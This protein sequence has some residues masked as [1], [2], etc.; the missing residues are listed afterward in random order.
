MDHDDD[1]RLSSDGDRWT[2]TFTRRLRHPQAKVWRAV[3]EPDGLRAWFPQRIEGERRAGAPLRF[4]HEDGSA[5]D[6]EMVAFEPTTLMEL[7]WGTDLLRIE[8]APDGDGTVLTLRDTFGE[9]GK[10]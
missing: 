4:V 1:G 6:G 3:T 5:F 9:L 8:L 2:L 10:A 7:R